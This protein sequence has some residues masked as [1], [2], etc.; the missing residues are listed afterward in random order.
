MKKRA[1]MI[2][3]LV[4]LLVSTIGFTACAS[5]PAEAIVIK[6]TTFQPG[7]VA[8]SVAFVE[9][10]T[11][12]EENSDGRIKVEYLGG[13]EVIAGTEQPLAVRNNTIQMAMVGGSQ[14]IGLVPEAL[15]LGL[16][17]ISPAEERSGGAN[18]LMEGYFNDGGLHFV[19]RMDPKELGNFWIAS[20]VEIKT[21][22]DFEG[23]R[24]V[25]NG[26]YVKAV[27]DALGTSFSVIKQADAYTGLERGMSDMYCTAL[28]VMAGIS[29]HE[30]TDY[31]IDHPL[32]K[33]N[34]S[35]IMN[36]DLWDSMSTDLQENVRATYLEWEPKLVVFS[37]NGL[38]AGRKTFEDAGVKFIKLSDADAAKFLDIAFTKEAESRIGKL[39]ETGPPYLKLVG[40]ID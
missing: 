14:L 6:A 32:Y 39:P 1:L 20:N 34:M 19:G 25:A 7:N 31:V 35:I 18:A 24:F 26:T 33:S 27:G 3:L 22:A 17:R 36:K 16:S 11:A 29:I 8:R 2:L 13:P 10:L 23:L 38:N 30:V 40:A 37:T 21:L 9:F 12:I 4:A 28:D 5:E 15:M